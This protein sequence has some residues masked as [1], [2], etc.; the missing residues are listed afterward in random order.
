MSVKSWKR[1]QVLGTRLHLIE[2]ATTLF[3]ERGFAATPLEEVV[4]RA[5]LTRGAVYH[6]FKDKRALFEDVLDER[7]LA[8]V[9]DVERRTVKRA[10][11]RG[12]EREGDVIEFFVEALR[13]P[14]THQ[15]VSVDGPSVLGRD[16]WSDLLGARLL[17]P[18]RRIVETGA[19]RQRL[20]ARLV[21]AITHLLFGAVQEAALLSERGRRRSATSEPGHGAR[22][23][24]LTKAE[25]DDALA[26]LLE[27]LLGRDS[28]PA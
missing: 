17:D 25:I 1:E 13:E 15:I 27:S 10:A 24:R 18:L 8:V 28:E 12:F 20:P 4:A 3:G 2:T 7:L 6:H 11:K 9:N 22:G 21:P 14:R 19:A 23:S 5:G 16:R 26:W